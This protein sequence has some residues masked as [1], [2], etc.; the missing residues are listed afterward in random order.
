M[1]AYEILQWRDNPGMTM[2]KVFTLADS[3]VTPEDGD[4]LIRSL[5]HQPI[6]F[7]SKAGQVVQAQD[8]DKGVTVREVGAFN[9]TEWSHIARVPWS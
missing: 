1:R 9:R 8:T 2:A 4:I 5:P 7:V 6:A 3:S